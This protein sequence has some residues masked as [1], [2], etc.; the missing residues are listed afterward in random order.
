MATMN[1]SDLLEGSTRKLQTSPLGDAILW[2]LE[3]KMEKA[4]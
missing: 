4:H 3:D 2:Y 1:I